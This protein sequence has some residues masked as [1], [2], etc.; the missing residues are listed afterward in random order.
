MH[1]VTVAEVEVVFPLSIRKLLTLLEVLQINI[2]ICKPL[3]NPSPIFM[4]SYLLSTAPGMFCAGVCY[5]SNFSCMHTGRCE[6]PKTKSEM[7][8]SKLGTGVQF[9][10]LQ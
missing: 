3:S 9:P 4:E 7:D 10:D 8:Q 2:N 6:G 1:Y 5:Y